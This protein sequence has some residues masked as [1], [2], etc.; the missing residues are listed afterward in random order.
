MD[1]VAQEVAGRV[2]LGFT[3]TRAYVAEQMKGIERAGT[4]LTS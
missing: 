3:I 1:W 4:T 2:P